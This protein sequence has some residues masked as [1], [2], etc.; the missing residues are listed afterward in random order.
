VAGRTAPRPVLR[1]V[2][3]HLLVLDRETSALILPCPVHLPRTKA[4][5]P[6]SA[7]TASRA[8]GKDGQSCPRL[9]WVTPLLAAKANE[10]GTCA[11]PAA[12]DKVLRCFRRNGRNSVPGC[13]RGHPEATLRPSG[14]QPVGTPRLPRGYPEAYSSPRVIHRS[15]ESPQ[16]LLPAASVNNSAAREKSLGMNGHTLSPDRE[17]THRPATNTEASHSM[18]QGSPSSRA[19]RWSLTNTQWRTASLSRSLYKPFAQDQ[20]ARF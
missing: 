3:H 20:P 17:N 8:P 15:E 5:G 10:N 12:S 11:S 2:T 1:L 18:T 9:A 19:T 4:P 13:P 7:R 14:S 6:L 16:G